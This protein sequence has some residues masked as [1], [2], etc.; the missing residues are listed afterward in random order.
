M[1]P[2][3]FSSV[4]EAGVILGLSFEVRRLGTRKQKVVAGRRRRFTES[5]GKNKHVF[6]HISEICIVSN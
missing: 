4:R 3:C 1:G 5:L 6:S 2:K